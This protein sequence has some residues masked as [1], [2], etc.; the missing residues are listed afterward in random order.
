MSNG[1]NECK[2]PGIIC[3]A[4]GLHSIVGSTVVMVVVVG[5]TLSLVSVD[6]KEPLTLSSV[7]LYYLKREGSIT[8]LIFCRN[9]NRISGVQQLLQFALYSILPLSAQS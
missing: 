8:L 9:V 3:P 4:G 7:F 2:V 1:I 6:R 5:S